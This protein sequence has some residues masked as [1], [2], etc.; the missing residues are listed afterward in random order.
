MSR[1][2]ISTMHFGF[3]NSLPILVPP[4]VLAISRTIHIMLNIPDPL[5]FG[6]EFE[7][8]VAT[9]RNRVGDPQ[10][11]S[12]KYKNTTCR[13]PTSMIRDYDEILE[14]QVEDGQGQNFRTYGVVA[15]C[16]ADKLTELNVPAYPWFRT[17]RRGRNSASAGK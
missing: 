1:N 14:Q 3:E 2:S 6:I 12:E 16:I 15:E 7:F 10:D 17:P 4:P 8:L 9:V 13:F 5:T 11:K